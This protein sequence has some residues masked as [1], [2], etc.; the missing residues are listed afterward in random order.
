ML[1][2]T[3]NKLH[4]MYLNCNPY[5]QLYLVLQLWNDTCHTR[6]D[7]NFGCNKMFLNY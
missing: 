4:L 1:D 2:K 5:A 6:P 7:Y 3:G